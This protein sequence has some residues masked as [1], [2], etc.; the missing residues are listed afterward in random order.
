MLNIFFGTLVYYTLEIIPYFDNTSTIACPYC[1]RFVGLRHLLHSTAELD[2]L[3]DD[4]SILLLIIPSMVTQQC[5]PSCD[6]LC[7][8][9]VRVPGCSST[10]PDLIP[11]ATGFSEK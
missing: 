5:M 10:G 3:L 4:D 8:L 11:G 2:F 6:R 9:V 1:E 7:G